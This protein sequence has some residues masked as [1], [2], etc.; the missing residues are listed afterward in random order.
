MSLARFTV[1]KWPS[2]YQGAALE[3]YPGNRLGALHVVW[4]QWG[5]Q[6]VSWPEPIA[7]RVP[8]SLHR[9]LDGIDR[10]LPLSYSFGRS[11]RGGMGA[12]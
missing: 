4:H 11:G 8:V 10:R 7:A 6:L 12:K 9:G 5:D 2:V 1:R 3:Q